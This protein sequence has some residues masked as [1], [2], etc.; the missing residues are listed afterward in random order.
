MKILASV[1]PRRSKRIRSAAKQQFREETNARTQ[2]D[3]ERRRVIERSGPQFCEGKL[4]CN[5]TT[6][7]PWPSELHLQK[8]AFRPDYGQSVSYS[9]WCN[10]RVEGDTGGYSRDSMR[11]LERDCSIPKFQSKCPRMP[12]Q[13]SFHARQ[14]NR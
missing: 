4:P 5:H 2:R 3:S 11:L 9:K 8:I 14:T 1:G 13:R 12:F 10:F 6:G 7:N